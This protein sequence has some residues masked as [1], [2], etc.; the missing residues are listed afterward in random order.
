[1]ICQGESVTAPPF[2]TWH[3]T[4]DALVARLD[5]YQAQT[6]Q[7]SI[8]A[9]LLRGIKLENK[10]KWRE[11]EL[12]PETFVDYYKKLVCTHGRDKG[13]RDE[14]YRTGHQRRGTDCPV[15]LCA[16]VLRCSE[17]GTIWVCATKHKRSHNHKLDKDG[18][19]H[20]PSNRKV[21]DPDVLDFV[22][23]LIRAGGKPRK[24]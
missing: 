13:C 21:T 4:W 14:G 24:F 3:D 23:E 2:E 8:Y 9:L 17:T 16:T 12:I 19:E 20:Y 10:E 18:F 6:S 22:D 7:L 15:I 1:M 11:A 5:E